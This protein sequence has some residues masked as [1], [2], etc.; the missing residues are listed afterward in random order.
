[1]KKSMRMFRFRFSVKLGGN[2]EFC[3]Q[4]ATKKE[5]L[6]KIY[7]HQSHLFDIL[8]KRPISYKE[9]V[10]YRNGRNRPANFVA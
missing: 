4:G 10:S 5:A 1:M 7:Q 8:V 6:D 3:A 9:L 2:A